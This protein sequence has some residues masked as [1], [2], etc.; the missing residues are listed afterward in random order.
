MET[1]KNSPEGKPTQREAGVEFSQIDIERLNM[2]REAFMAKAAELSLAFD[3][4]LEKVVDVTV[5]IFAEEVDSVYEE[6]NKEETLR[7]LKEDD[8]RFISDRWR[9][10][11]KELEKMAL[12]LEKEALEKLA[13]TDSLTGLYLRGALDAHLERKI[14]SFRHG[15]YRQEGTEP[16]DFSL[17]MLDLDNFKSINDTFGHGVGDNV[18]KAVAKVIRDSIRGEDFPAR[19]GG[20]EMSVVVRGDIST[21][22]MLAERLCRAIEAIDV[23]ELGIDKTVRNKITAS[24]GV[25]EYSDSD[26]PAD[27]EISD[28]VKKF[29][30]KI[31]AALYVAKNSGKNRVVVV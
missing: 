24:I 13:T 18:L 14:K 28:T 19:P 16:N 17:I 25:G 6:E 10:V 5:R 11:K 8:P 1:P 26:D 29:V 15:H 20:E 4:P 23:T 2:S 30:E 21:A 27:V 22:K 31:D 3:V 9:L 12:E 7:L